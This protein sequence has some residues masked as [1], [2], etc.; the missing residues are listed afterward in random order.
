MLRPK[1][2]LVAIA[3][4]PAPDLGPDRQAQAIEIGPSHLGPGD[5]LARF[6]E[7][8]GFSL[9]EVRDVTPDF[10]RVAEVAS[11]A[12][13]DHRDALMSAEGEETWEEEV[14][15][16]SRMARGVDEGLL[17]RTLVLAERM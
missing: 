16:K 5:S 10:R 13:A 8:A 7:E 4:E 14:D 12:L 17:V 1:G 2:R 3:I 11:L 6:A 9:L 15:R